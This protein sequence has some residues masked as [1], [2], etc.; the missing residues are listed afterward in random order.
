[1]APSNE[2]KAVI[3]LKHEIG[4]IQKRQQEELNLLVDE[5]T[6][7]VK[8]DFEHFFIQKYQKEDKGSDYEKLIEQLN[9]WQKKRLNLINERDYA[10][11][12]VAKQ[13]IEAELQFVDKRIGSYQRKTERIKKRCQQKLDELK[14]FRETELQKLYESINDF[15]LMTESETLQD[16]ISEEELE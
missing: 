10:E 13:E 15:L 9:F 3:Q 11:S 16:D 4:R 5:V 1:M 7:R 12:E 8:K 14:K 2:E 6:Q